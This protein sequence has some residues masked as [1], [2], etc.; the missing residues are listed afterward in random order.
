MKRTDYQ[1]KLDFPFLFIR[2][3]PCQTAG[4]LIYLSKYRRGSGVAPSFIYLLG[5]EDSDL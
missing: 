4:I 1:Q 3:P 2:L 5:G